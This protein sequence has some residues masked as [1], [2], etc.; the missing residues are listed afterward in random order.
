MQ[1]SIVHFF[2]KAWINY[3]ENK[4]TN[5]EHLQVKINGITQNDNTEVATH[6]ND[7][8]FNCVRDLADTFPKPN[9]LNYLM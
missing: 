3:L 6:F 5:C 1:K 9:Y 8:F 7:Y 2:G 4:K